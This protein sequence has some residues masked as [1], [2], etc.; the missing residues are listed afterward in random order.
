MR[1]A[2][3][4]QLVSDE[5]GPALGRMHI[6]SHVLTGFGKTP[7]ELIEQGVD[8]REIWWQLCRDFDVPESRWLGED[9]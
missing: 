5:F 9:Y 6:E 8:V 4:H 3:F 7:A 1:L 2:Q